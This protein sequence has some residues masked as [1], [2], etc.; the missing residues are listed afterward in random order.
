MGIL[1]SC[2]TQANV[3]DKAWKIYAK[4][5]LI[6]NIQFDDFYTAYRRHLLLAKKPIMGIINYKL[7]STEKRMWII[8]TNNGEVLEKTYAA[9]GLNSGLKRA[10]KFSN[11]IN[12]KQTSLGVFLG[13]ETYLGK[14]GYSLRLDGVSHSNSKAR[15]RAIVIHGADYVSESYIE[16][17]GFLGRSWGCPAV[18]RSVSKRVIDLLKFGST[19]HSLG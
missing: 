2:N 4:A 13:A 16:E 6:E 19:I 7:P 8:D 1:F 9:H 10:V 12:S 3:V 15:D 5:Q 17:N 18:P 14:H 11:T